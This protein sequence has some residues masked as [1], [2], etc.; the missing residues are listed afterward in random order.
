[1]QMN[2][3]LPMKKNSERVKNKNMRSFGGHPL[4]HAVLKELL[5]VDEVK[6]IFINTDSEII[7]ADAKERFGD[8][9]T[10]VDRP[11]EL[12][13]D[14]VSMN[15]II[16][17]DINFSAG[18]H[19][20]QTHS[21]NPLLKASA[22]RDAIDKYKKCIERY[23]SLFT[24]TKYQTRFFDSETNPINH[25]RSILLRTQDLPPYFEEN[26]NMYL[27][28]SESFEA[29]GGQRIGC[30]PQMYV[31][32]KLQAIDI[33]DQEDFDLAEYIYKSRGSK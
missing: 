22:I 15:R 6:Q 30:H 1:M 33:D 10:I 18:Q 3:L 13:G 29:S 17:Y 26:S 23:D 32:P 12:R 2:V 11:E 21:T 19:F 9:V 16:E 7:S 25:D 27:F 5:L 14:H 8:K 24:V 4:Y 28:S 20:L 31:M